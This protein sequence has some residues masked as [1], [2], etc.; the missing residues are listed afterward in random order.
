MDFFLEKSEKSK[1]CT[2][3]FFIMYV[4]YKQLKFAWKNSNLKQ[5]I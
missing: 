4:V 1:N 3:M 2:K 5:I